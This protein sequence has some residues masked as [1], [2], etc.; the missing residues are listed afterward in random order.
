MFM[1]NIIQTKWFIWFLNNL[2]I[3]RD[4]LDYFCDNS[5]RNRNATFGYY[6]F[7]GW[8]IHLV[9]YRYHFN[10]QAELGKS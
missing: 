7:L 5:R 3:R 9:Q 10:H 2:R 4:T 8:S 6:R 1:K